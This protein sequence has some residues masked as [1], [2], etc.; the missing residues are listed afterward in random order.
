MKYLLAILTAALLLLG[1]GTAKAQLTYTAGNATVTLNTTT[2][3][4][5]FTVSGNTCTIPG[6]GSGTA[7]WYNDRALIRSVSIQGNYNGSGTVQF[8]T[9]AF[10][11]CT[12]LTSVSTPSGTTVH[13]EPYSFSGCTALAGS[14]TFDANTVNVGPYAFQNCTSL[15]YFELSN[16]GAQIAEGA[17]YG[18]SALTSVQYMEAVTYIS[19]YA[20]YGCTSLASISLSNSLTGIGSSA[21]Q[22]CTSLTSV[23]MPS[24]N[25]NSIGA[26]AFNGCAALAFLNILRTSGMVTLSNAN[27]LTGVHTSFCVYVPQARLAD[28]QGDASWSA[29]DLCIRCG[30]GGAGW[31]LD[32][33]GVLTIS[34]NLASSYLPPWYSQRS[35]ITSVVVGSSVTAIGSYTFYGCNNLAE[36]TLPSSVTSIGTYAFSGCTA[37]VALNIL[38]TSSMV[39]LAS[40]NALQNVHADFCVYVPQAQLASYQ[41]SNLW[42]PSSLSPARCIRCGVGGKMG[43]AKWWLNCSGLLSITEIQN[44]NYSIPSYSTSNRPPWYPYRTQITSASMGGSYYTSS[45]VVSVG[46]YAFQGCTNMTYFNGPWNCIIVISD[47][48]FSGCTALQSLSDWETESEPIYIGSYAFQN[49]TSLTR[50]FAQGVGSADVSLGTNVFRGCTALTNVSL[51]G[52]YATEYMFYGCTNLT[53][54]SFRALGTVGTYA[55]YNCNKL[56]TINLSGTSSIGDYAFYGCSSLSAL[57]IPVATSIGTQA[58]RGCS[59]VASVN[60]PNLSSLGTYA[61][62]GCSSLASVTLPSNVTSIGAYTFYNCSALTSLMLARTAGKVTLASTNAL[63]GVNS[64]FCV[65]VP[66]A[67]RTAYQEDPIWN[68]SSLS[69]ARCIQCGTNGTGWSLSCSGVLTISNQTAMADYT[70]QN[71]VPWYSLRSQVTSVVVNSGIT[72]IGNYAFY[73]CSNVTSVSLPGNLTSIGASAFYGCSSLPAVTIPGNV[74][75]IGSYAFRDCSSLAS[76]SLPNSLTSIG[77]YAFYGCSSLPAITIPSGVTTINSYAFYSCAALASV[78]LLGNV[79]SIGSYAFRGCS[80][81]PA[82]SLPASLTSIGTYAFYG[83]SSLASI[84]IPANVA[85][86]GTYAFFNCSQLQSITSLRLTPPTVTNANTFTNVPSSCCL[87]VL[88]VALA[89]YEDALYWRDFSC[90]SSSTYTVTFLARGGELIPPLEDVPHCGLVPEPSPEPTREGHVFVG[91]FVDSCDLK[92]WNFAEDMVTATTQLYANWATNF[93]RVNFNTRGGTPPVPPDNVPHGSRVPEPGTVPTRENYT[94]AGWYADTSNWSAVGWNFYTNRITS[95]T[96]LFAK[97]VAKKCLITFD[98]RGG[99]PV[100]FDSVAYGSTAAPP[101]VAPTRYGYSLVGW[102]AD[103]AYSI[104]WDFSTSKVTRDTTLYAKWT[105]DYGYYLVTFD[106]RGGAPKPEVQVAAENSTTPRPAPDPA[107]NGYTFVGWIVDTVLNVAWSFSADA[108]TDHTTLYALW[109]L[110]GDTMYTVTFDPLNGDPLSMRYVA[111][112]STVSRPAPDPQNWGYIFDGWYAEADTVNDYGGTEWSFG[113]PILSDTTLFAKWR[114]EHVFYTVTFNARGGAPTPNPQTV[115]EG[116]V[117]QRPADPTRERCDFGG[118]YADSLSWSTAWSFNTDTVAKNMT[119]YALWIPMHTVTFYAMGGSPE[120]L[121]R[122]VQHDSLTFEPEPPTRYTFT[123]GGWYAEADTVNNFGGSAWDFSTDRVTADTA[124]FARWAINRYAITYAANGGTSIAPDTIAHGD[125]VPQPTDPDRYGYTFGGWYAET[126]TVNSYSGTAY[127]FGSPVIGELTLFAKWTRKE[128]YV[129]FEVRGGAPEPDPNPQEVL[130]ESVAAEPVPA[131]VRY[132]HEFRGWYADSTY[133][134]SRWSFSVNLITRDTTLYALWAILPMHDVT[135]NARNGSPLFPY[136]VAEGSTVARPPD[137]DRYGYTFAGWYADSIGWSDIWDFDTYLVVSDTT[138][139][140]KWTVNLYRVTF[141][142]R[143]GESPLDSMVAYGSLVTAPDSA[144]KREGYDFI[145]WVVDTMS[146]TAWNF[147]TSTVTRDTTLYARWRV[148]EYLVTFDQLYNNIRAWQPVNYNSLVPKPENPERAGYLFAGWYADSSFSGSRW[149]F[150]ADLVTGDTTLYAL[151]ASA[152]NIPACEGR[153]FTLS[154]PF[155]LHSSYYPVTYR[156][157]R[158]GV[159]FGSES[160]VSSPNHKIILSVPA[161]DDAAGVNVLFYFEYKLNDD[162]PDCWTRSP[163]YKVNFI[164]Q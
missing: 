104:A 81:L 33:S 143:N 127:D 161:G 110:V 52:T 40:T 102:Y 24:N 26:N 55:F 30:M 97:W 71:Y 135:F 90:L 160:T 144:P 162:C 44:S 134:G 131:P 84:T 151:W 18:C 128:F 100:T 118:W 149:D 13:F 155:R 120:P 132:G 39:T 49:C 156:W 111:H 59:G 43:G 35:S 96:T 125:T 93:Y 4:M 42:N 8:G 23:T 2:G 70:S 37:L 136:T 89:A 152:A 153:A 61:F 29:N 75:S 145:G 150:S 36:I 68:P 63:T 50:F 6:Y 83:C 25:L 57:N 78:S 19:N 108:V 27:A 115:P 142:A 69:P 72:S 88:R 16:G 82:I 11:N 76:V 10:Y 99:T 46:D 60:M 133:S 32:C 45:T 164:P 106:A 163:N 141:N 47:Y 114:P 107:R 73:G 5:V 130:Y 17:F 105:L 91:W 58:F 3:A 14:P 77:T 64:G 103:S 54:V 122:T 129:S 79:T 124:L 94:F 65:Y 123:F 9:Y 117:V 7:P 51:R 56:T 138:L 147:G 92:P 113:T 137:P 48:A 126:D 12:N 1:A 74:I 34:T 112:D 148:K 154:I 62:Y 66:S 116:S 146:N 80:S 157:Y 159:S 109:T 101:A 22:N 86:I 95:D 15:T 121:P 28:Y 87:W 20:F 41:A 53:S 98:A 85:S 67:L 31:E 140:A 158:N 119:L 38:N 21:F 139:F